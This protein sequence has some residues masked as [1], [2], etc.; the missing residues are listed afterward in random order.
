MMFRVMHHASYL[1]RNQPKSLPCG[2]KKTK[3]KMKTNKQRK[4]LYTERYYKNEVFS[5][6]VPNSP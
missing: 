4:Q 3:I 2:D 5:V 1:Q 6:C